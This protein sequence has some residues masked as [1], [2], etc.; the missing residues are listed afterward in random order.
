MSTWVWDDNGFQMRKAA[1]DLAQLDFKSYS[2]QPLPL[3][4]TVIERAEA[5]LAFLSAGKAPEEG[6]VDLSGQVLGASDTQ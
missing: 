3:A 1:L 4:E 2:G 6:T 5:Y